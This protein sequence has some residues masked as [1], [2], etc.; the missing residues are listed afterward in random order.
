MSD[1]PQVINIRPLGDLRDVK[2]SLKICRSSVYVLMKEDEEFPQPFM[3]R[4][5]LF[6]FLDEIETYKATRPRRRYSTGG[7]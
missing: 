6:W 2:A 1:T 3:I 5:K 4:R 7:A